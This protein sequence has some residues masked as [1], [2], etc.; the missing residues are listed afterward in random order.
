MFY[1]LPILL[2]FIDLLV[3][4]FF[5]KWIISSLFIFF[6]LVN[7]LDGY[8]NRLIN[9]ILIF[10]FFIQ[11]Y[12]FYG[13]VGTCFFYIL[14][15]L[16]FAPYLRKAINIG[17]VW[18]MGLFLILIQFYRLF[19]LEMLVLGRIISYHS[20]LFNISINIFI[21]SL[22]LLGMRGNRS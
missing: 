12:F 2:F 3:F 18:V 13:I 8:E 15:V 5:Q 10:L 22:I 17:S 11:D 7:F 1:T 20:T 19:F 6:I 14:P 4:L 9:I 21:G 16:I